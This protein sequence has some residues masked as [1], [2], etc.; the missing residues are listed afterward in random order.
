M[1]E[2]PWYGADSEFLRIP[3]VTFVLNL[4]HFYKLLPLKPTLLICKKPFADRYSPYLFFR[5]LKLATYIN[6]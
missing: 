2:N 3:F 6:N 1:E 4:L 5:S